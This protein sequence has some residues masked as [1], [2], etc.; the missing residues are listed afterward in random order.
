LAAGAS[1]AGLKALLVLPVAGLARLVRTHPAFDLLFTLA[2]AAEVIGTAA[3]VYDSLAWTDTLSHLALPLLSGPILYLGLIRLGAVSE[4]GAVP[5]HRVLVGT[6]VITAIAVMCL[7]ALWELVEW[8]ADGTVATN[9]SQGYDDT[10]VD[11]WVDAIAAVGAGALVAGWLRGQA[12]A[13]R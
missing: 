1:S 9:Y 6:V 7:G 4:P 3:G 13:D 12:E 10:I 2:L 5:T 11:L 8:V